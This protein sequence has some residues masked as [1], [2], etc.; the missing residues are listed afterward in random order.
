MDEDLDKDVIGKDLAECIAE[1]RELRAARA[2]DPE[3]ADYPLLKQ[4]QADRLART[5][6]DLLASE[7]Y[8]PAAEF[9]LSD[10]YGPKDF[11]GRDDELARVV[12]VMVRV[13]PARALFTL[14]EA[15]KMDTLSESLDTDMVNA[16]RAAGRSH[17]I[18]GEAYAA[19][20]RACGRRAD[21]EQQIALVDKIGTTLDRLTHIP[22]IRVSLR[23]MEGPA[24]LAGLSA[25][26][27]FL[28]RGFDAFSEM[29][30]AEEFLAIV[31][32]RETAMMK[33][34]FG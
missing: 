32:T 9:F 6:A 23:I 20:Y 7:R 24:Y 4:W 18:D 30:G 28:Q 26:H 34:W 12:P 13:L 15:V 16:L 11:R 27:S 25:L 17:D 10:L 21:R 5:Y 22:L 19:A 31:T 1:A 29:H 33:E 3:A 14:L 2:S 8:A